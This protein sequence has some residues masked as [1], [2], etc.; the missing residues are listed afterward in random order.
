MSNKGK[1]L[2]FGG[3]GQLGQCISK[4]IQNRN[5]FSYVFLD[6]IE[7]NILDLEVLKNLFVRESP[8]FVVN[9]A[10]YTAVDKAE[11]EPE[12]CEKINSNGAAN[13][14]RFCAEF[15]AT[16]IHIST[17]FVFEGN[18]PALLK[19]TDAA[20]PINVYGQTKLQGELEIAGH[21]EAHYILRTSWLYSEFAGNFVKTML[22]LGAEREEL[23]V[24]VDQVGTPT[25]GVD[26]A[27]VILDLIESDHKAAYGTYHYS[28]D[29]LCSWYDFAK[30]IFEISGTKLTVY[31]IPTSA[32]PTKAR[33]PAFSVMDKTKIKTTFNLEIPYWRDSLVKCIHAIK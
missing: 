30:A 2:V 1:V 9:C 23:S 24:I 13:L 32:Y 12:L 31:P 26:L 21:L 6:E 7:G 19:E 18:V 22:K 3:I 4:V 29:G 5:S 28:N 15:K 10:A 8:D 16:M 11:D 17:D 33:R 14:A 20:L 27:A 25:Y